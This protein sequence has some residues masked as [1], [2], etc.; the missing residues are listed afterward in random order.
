MNIIPAGKS[1]TVSR[2][3]SRNLYPVILCGGSGKRLWPLS[4]QA[5]PKQLL[6]LATDRTM[7]QETVD[8]AHSLIELRAP[9]VLCSEEH[10]FLVAEQLAEIEI[11]PEAILCEPISRNTA[12]ALAMAAAYLQERDPGAI[13]LALPADHH[14]GDKQA[15]AEA[16]FR[17]A[18][19][20][21]RGWL[22]TFG[23]Q[24][25]RAETGYGYIER[26][27][28]LDGGIQGIYAVQRF[29]EK[30]DAATAEILLADG[31]HSWNSGMF[32]LPVDVFLEQLGLHSPAVTSAA[33]NAVT[34]GQFDAPYL[35]L[36]RDALA[37]SP[38]ESVDYALMEHTNRAVVIPAEMDWSDIGSWSALRDIR[39]P[40]GDG[41]VLKGNVVVDGVRNSFV[42]ANGRLVTVMGLEDVIVVDTEDALL[43]SHADKS[44][45][46][47]DLVAKLKAKR[48]PESSEHSKV[49][50]PWGAYESVEMGSRFQVKHIE[51][52]PG[53][54]LSLQMHHHRAE[55][56]V[57]VSGTARVTCGT[58]TQTLYENQSVFIPIGSLHRL[59]NPGR[60][61]LHLIEVQIGSYL[62][63]NDIVRFEDNYGR[64]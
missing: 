40:D 32:M 11:E 29:I 57:V 54:Q 31:A 19:A 30:P 42:H 3:R 44:P 13:M 17:A 25:T 18:A 9:V 49:R 34:V 33:Y 27:N 21:E 26:G 12:P 61:P 45:E 63:E 38:D 50:R 39:Q 22:A 41:N 10:R 8:R 60:I 2:S 16:V 52:K 59:E 37:E 58:E 51:V 4:R 53:G 64:A 1:P 48:I 56:W 36:D 23:I 20:A 14:I 47:G 7:L 35:H 24:P 15:F 46:V 28:L 5:Y 43:V 6:P 55:H 62:G